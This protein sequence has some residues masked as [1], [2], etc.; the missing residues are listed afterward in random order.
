MINLSINR[1]SSFA[2]E[3]RKI[4][5][6]AATCALTLLFLRRH[7][8]NK[9][10]PPV[11]VLRSKQIKTLPDLVQ[12]KTTQQLASLYFIRNKPSDALAEVMHLLMHESPASSLSLDEIVTKTQQ[13]WFRKNRWE[14]QEDDAA[15]IELAPKVDPLLKRLGIMETF[16][17]EGPYDTA[18][19]LGG[20]ANLFISRL[21]SLLTAI[22]DRRI[23]V[24]II[25]ILIGT[26]P[27]H[28]SELEILATSCHQITGAK[29]EH[30]MA[31][32]VAERM[33]KPL[34]IDYHIIPTDF[35]DKKPSTEQTIDT[36]IKVT[37]QNRKRVLIISDPQFAVYQYFQCF[38][39]FFRNHFAGTYCVFVNSLDAKDFKRL[40]VE[41]E[42]IPRSLHLDTISR[43][44][45]TLRSQISR[46]YFSL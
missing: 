43:T 4:I 13:A 40:K 24:S 27:L 2:Y 16:I 23:Q 39:S 9:A 42:T 7:Q 26:Q 17:P 3:H 44:I 28:P 36:W 32:A 10:M 11:E 19:L 35:G 45:F 14:V 46:G 12:A 1:I 41:E 21:D 33:I 34:G 6:G 22:K 5:L 37:G 8:K 38:E 20:R 31:I 18:L 25:D 15:M 30:D 29:T